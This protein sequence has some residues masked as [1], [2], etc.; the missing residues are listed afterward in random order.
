MRKQSFKAL[1]TK[2]IKHE[3]QK[4]ICENTSK[5]LSSESLRKLP[6]KLRSKNKKKKKVIRWKESGAHR[7][8]CLLGSCRQY[9]ACAL[10]SHVKTQRAISLSAEKIKHTSCQAMHE[11]S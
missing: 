9:S 2:Y 11:V 5:E 3:R 7:E 8:V 4:N 6:G 10:K 1:V